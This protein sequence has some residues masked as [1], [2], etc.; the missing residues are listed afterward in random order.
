MERVLKAHSP[1]TPLSP[2]HHSD[3]ILKIKRFR[4]LLLLWVQWY[5]PRSHSMTMHLSCFL[6]SRVGIY[7][8][9]S[10][11]VLFLS[12][13]QAPSFIIITT[14]CALFF[15]FTGPSWTFSCLRLTLS[16]MSVHCVM[17]DCSGSPLIFHSRYQ[18]QSPLSGKTIDIWIYPISTSD[19]PRSCIDI[20]CIFHSSSSFCNSYNSSSCYYQR[21][22]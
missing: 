7:C 9:S 3:I 5:L 15:L 22:G 19:I 21:Y 6:E 18:Q 20:Q 11:V 17:F 1:C 2:K 4:W 12:F 14:L 10:E 16:W 13:T 8:S